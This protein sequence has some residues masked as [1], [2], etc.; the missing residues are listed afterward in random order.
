MLLKK[1]QKPS[2]KPSPISNFHLKIHAVRESGVFSAADLA[3]MHQTPLP[4]SWMMERRTMRLVQRKCGVQVQHQAFPI[5]LT[6]CLYFG[7]AKDAQKQETALV[8]IV[9]R[10]TQ[11]I[12]VRGSHRSISFDSRTI[13]EQASCTPPNGTTNVLPGTTRNVRQILHGTDTRCCP[14]LV[15]SKKRAAV[16]RRLV[17]EQRKRGFAGNTGLARKLYL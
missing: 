12:E 3:N 11:E 5:W 8:H 15:L 14:N 16:T 17:M 10:S 1:N 2:I 6:T 13:S 7:A 4:L 9:S